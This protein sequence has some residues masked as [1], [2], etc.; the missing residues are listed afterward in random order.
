MTHRVSFQITSGWAGERW[1]WE[2]TRAGAGRSTFLAAA[3]T[4][5]LARSVVREIMLVTEP[6]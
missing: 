5:A 3:A 4:V 6:V 2:K 1:K